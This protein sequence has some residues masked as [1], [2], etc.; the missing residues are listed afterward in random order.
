M[1][2]GR[3]VNR[4]QYGPGKRHFFLIEGVVRDTKPPI[5]RGRGY[6][7]SEFVE[8]TGKPAICSQIAMTNTGSQYFKDG[9]PVSE[10]GGLSVVE[11][12][13]LNQRNLCSY[14]V[15]K[16]VIEINPDLEAAYN[17]LKGKR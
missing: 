15:K 10:Y 7:A 17:I 16:Y 13:N 4:K 6:S 3:W 12:P 8:S 14:C 9:K 5:D 11:N 1:G 2:L